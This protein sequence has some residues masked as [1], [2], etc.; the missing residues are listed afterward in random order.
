MRATR[1][2]P[3]SRRRAP[4]DPRS[5]M[6][7]RG[8]RGPSP[9]TMRSLRHDLLPVPA[10]RSRPDL[11]RSPKRSHPAGSSPTTSASA[12]PP[13]STRSSCSR[14]SVARVILKAGAAST[15]CDA[16]LRAGARHHDIDA[17]SWRQKEEVRVTAT[18][19]EGR[20]H[21]A[22]HG[23]LHERGAQSCPACLPQESRSAEFLPQIL[24]VTVS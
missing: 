20:N 21:A 13:C 19:N 4:G 17:D 1:I 11:L 2:L 16:G 24:H 10:L 23:R 9:S 6:R 15:S 7:E 12:V 22:L 18:R 5:R 8:G 14:R 3:P